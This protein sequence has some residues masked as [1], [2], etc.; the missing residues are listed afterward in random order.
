VAVELPDRLGGLLGA[1][2]LDEGETTRA[3]AHPIGRQRDVDRLG[4]LGEQ[5]PDVLKC[6]VEAQIA[7]ENL[8]ADGSLLSLRT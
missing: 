7:Y 4:D 1:R 5:G 6:D 8:G 2:E 3:A